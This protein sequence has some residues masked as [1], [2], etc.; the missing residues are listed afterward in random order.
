MATGLE[1]L[2]REP[3][4]TE[5]VG[6]QGDG[7]GDM[8]VKATE[9]RIGGGYARGLCGD[10]GYDNVMRMVC[11]Y[12]WMFCCFLLEGV[13]VM[14]CDTG[15]EEEKNTDGQ[16]GE[17]KEEK[18]REVEREQVVERVDEWRNSRRKSR[19]ADTKMSRG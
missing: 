13:N 16:E 8:M 12:A 15:Y 19:G 17:V 14:R 18:R 7:H 2:S 11:L 4:Q 9:G 1:F 6:E 10:A 5:S 3:E